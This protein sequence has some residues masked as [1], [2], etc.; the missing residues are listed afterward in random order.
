MLFPPPPSHGRLVD[1]S[2]SFST[3]IHSAQSANIGAIP[4]TAKRGR[5]RSEY[6]LNEGPAT[7]A[8]CEG[9]R[10]DGARS[11]RGPGRLDGGRGLGYPSGVRGA[12]GMRANSLHRCFHAL[13]A[14]LAGLVVA[15]TAAGTT[16]LP[17]DHGPSSGD[18]DS[19]YT[20]K[21]GYIATPDFPHMERAK[22]ARPQARQFNDRLP[23]FTFATIGDSHVR[24]KGPPDQ[25]FLKALDVAGDLLANY[26]SDINNSIPPVDFAVHLGDI[27]DLGFPEEFARCRAILDS[28]IPPLYPLV[29]NHDNFQSDA[30]LGWKTFAGRDS[31]NYSFDHK[32]LHFVMIDCTLDPYAPPYVDCDSTVRSW[33]ARDLARNSG[34]P[35]IL[36]SHFNM[37]ERPWNAMFDTT[38]HYA[39]YRGMPELREVLEAAG[40]VIAVI[41]GHVHANRVEEHNGIYYIDVGAT[42]VGPPSLRYF[43]VY[44]DRIVVTYSYISREPLFDYVTSLCPQCAACFDPGAV[45]SFIDGEA[46]QRAFTMPLPSFAGVPLTPAP[47]AEPVS[48][49]LALRYDGAGRVRA[50]VSSQTSG[51]VDLAVHDVLG[52]RVD[53]RSFYKGDGDLEINLAAELAGT[54]NLPAGVYFLRA[55]FQGSARTQ[56]MILIP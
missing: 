45:C 56:K 43:Q 40:N 1:G 29:G 25:R 8:P 37:W 28:L 9:L 5:A 2:A 26:V 12:G 55:S 21:P 54:R 17:G 18:A 49:G 10:P 42:L 34:E 16:Q 47:A 11:P 52:R 32:G 7:R 35:T 4:W 41:N 51:T 22:P 15:A 33:V 36:F 46:G 24:L 3:N 27:T 6:L 30:K 48:F 44:P 53:R 50:V 13:S 39:E 20:L 31:T 38:L 14:A 23:N 19:A